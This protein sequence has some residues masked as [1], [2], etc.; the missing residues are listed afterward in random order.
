MRGKKWFILLASLALVLLSSGIGVTRSSFVDLESSTGNTFQAWASNLWLQ[1]TQADFNAGLLQNVQV[2]SPGDVKLAVKSGWYNT[3]WQYRRAITIDHT[4]VQD[5][6]NPSTTYANFPVLVYATG[7]SNIKADGAD[8][9][10]TSSDGVTELPREIESYS[11][12]TLY[13]WVKVTLTKDAGDSSNDIIYMYYGNSAATEPAPGSTYGSQNVWD[14]NYK[15]V[16]HLKENPTGT[17]PQ[18]KDSTSNAHDGTTTGMVSGDQIAAG[19]I[20]GSLNFD[21]LDAYVQTTSGESKTASSITWSVWFKAD[22]T[23][24]SH[25]ILWEGPSTQNGWGEPGQAATHEMHL[26]IGRMSTANLLDFFYGYEYTSGNFIPAVE[27]QTAFSDTVNWHYAVVVLTGADSSPSGTLYLD[28]NLIGTDT[29]TETGRSAWDTNLRIGR[30]GA[31]QRYLD[32]IADEVRVSNIARSAEWITT[33]YNNQNSPSTFCSVGGEEGM[34]VSSGTIASQVLNTGV[35]GAR[36]DA[37]FWD[38]I[39][40]SGTDITF[41]VRASDSPFAKDTPDA[42][43]PW[44]S[45]GGTSPVTSGLPSG[46]YMQWQAILTTSDTSK[47]PTLQEV[48]VYYY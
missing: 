43:L 28:G 33:E 40:E 18:M 37:L 30:C 9:R 14:S 47:T 10:F 35:S 21:G 45:V 7:L 15:G 19:K 27:I 6:A 26:T 34:Y 38:E 11:G 24:G 12:G 44:I 29:G 16:W 5:V 3:N 32:G 31:N 39:L 8:I 41:A 17:A 36:W 48:R 2:V 25:H 1:T 20:D 23:T 46:Q 4:K 42:T 22:S 13:A